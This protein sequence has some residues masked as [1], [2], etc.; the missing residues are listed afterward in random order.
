MEVPR[1]ND[2]P[3]ASHKQTL[4]HNVVSSTPRPDGI[5]TVNVSGEQNVCI[6][7]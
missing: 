5:R 4:S 2:R 6:G 7:S 3:V 1:E